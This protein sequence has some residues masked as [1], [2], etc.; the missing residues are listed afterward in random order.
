M[1]ETEAKKEI[2][3]LTE[4]LRE[5][6]YNYYVLSKSLISDYDFDIKLKELEKLES[7][8]P[9]LRQAGSP[10]RRVGGEPSKDFASVKHKYPMLSLS[11]SYSEQDIRD[12]DQRVRKV[13]GDEVEY[14][15]EL[16]YDGV[17]IGLRYE[18]GVLA[19]AV[20]RGD[21]NQGDDVT[22]NVKT[23]KSIPLKL[24]GDYPA[25]LEIRGEIFFPLKDFERINK[26]RLENGEQTFANPRNSASGTL[27]MQDPKE[28][29]HRNLDCFLYYFPISYNNVETHYEAMQYAASLG[30]KVS[31]NMAL[32]KNIDEIFEFINDWETGRHGLPYEIDGIVIKVNQ[33]KMQQQLA[34]TAKSP[35]WAIAYKFKAERAETKLESVGFQVGRTGAVTPV[36][37]LSPVQLAG[38]TVKRASLHN[39]DIINK[40]DLHYNDYVYV[41]KGGEIIP[42]IVGINKSKRDPRADK[43]SFALVCPE[44]GSGLV[45]TEGESAFYCPNQDNCPPQIKGKLEHFISRKAMNIDSLGEGKVEMLYDNGLLGNVADLY[46]LDYDSL[47]GLEKVIPATE[48]KKEKKLSL[49]DKSVRNILSGLENSKK[50]GFEKVL[51]ALGI[52]HIGETVAKKLA[53][54][55]KS[56][57]KLK[58]ASIEQLTELEDIG[59]K[60]AIS[61]SEWF[62]DPKH[63]TIIEELKK[64]GLDFEIHEEDNINKTNKLE[65]KSFV[66]SGVFEQF[67]RNEIK[68]LIEE[69]GGKN[70]GSV[71]AKTNYLLA[72]ANMGPAKL[73]K[74]E[75]LGVRIISEEEFRKMIDY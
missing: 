66:V 71:S 6:N 1:T 47:I 67:S 61:L 21:G 38:T 69:N 70:I 4:E 60:I 3:K 59:D 72:G 24:R 45:R 27:K 48:E 39:A 32:C 12:F 28:V 40:L 43:V 63:Q 68:Q 9:G 51:F 73:A 14:V 36:A 42:K 20:T 13:V 23:I 64:S 5:Y 34:F 74:A 17:A 29:A 11:N 15:C 58:D 53:A 33:L 65:G 75:K 31:K 18:K 25:E 2:A 49:R 19:Q 52:R 46:K 41:E 8:F 26:E 22:N 62:K 30:F 10:T 57:D 54:R 16:K 35:R 37:N 44:C 56:I 55:F 50:L 7:K